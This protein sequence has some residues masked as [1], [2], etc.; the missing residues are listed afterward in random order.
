[1]KKMLSVILA[2]VLCLGCLS[3]LAEVSGELLVYT[4]ADDR[5]ISEICN[6]FN[7]KYPNAHAE[8]YRSGTEEVVSKLM[9]EK[10]TNSIQADIIMIS[11]TP[12]ME[13]FKANDMLA[14]YESPEIENICIDF[15]DPERMY[16]GT[17]PT[18][19]G[20]CYN[21]N[22]AEKPLTSW[23]DLLEEFTKD[24]AIMPSPL[25]S[26]TACYAMMEITRAEG[27]GWDYYQGLYDNGIMVV[28]GNG[29]VVNSVAA[30][31]KIYG[32]VNESACFTAIN[33]GSPLAF[34]YQEEG[35]PSTCD[36]VAILKT[37][38]NVSAA[39]AFVDFMLSKDIQELGR[40]ILGQTPT[41]A[42]V[43]LGAGSM[44]LS[45]RTLMIN[46]AKVL[47]E[48][49]EEDKEVFADMFDM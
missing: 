20:I 29:G 40:D 26:G 49:R 28:N 27:L 19:M 8:Y 47:Y 42:E 23:K 5:L 39:Q 38:E 33:K 16:Y 14:V 6:R 37:T 43:T 22:L 32:I 25:Y 12:T 35:V 4:S 44:P 30:G 1:M 17:F 11:D 18:A 21:T 46:D 48:G 34:V 41:R 24:N 9:A 2:L 36:P 10:M 13:M 7:A 15:V 45:E 31:E 3:A